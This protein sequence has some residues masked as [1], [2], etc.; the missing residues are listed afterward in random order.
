M[1]R[2][3]VAHV[4]EARGLPVMD[5]STLLTDAYVE[6]SLGKLVQRTSVQRKTLS[7]VWDDK[8]RFEITSDELLMEGAWPAA[9]P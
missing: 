9:G 5:R 3:L 8:L 7:P 4:R 6:V 2:I 1:P